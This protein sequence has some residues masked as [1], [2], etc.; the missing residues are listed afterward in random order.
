ML[1]FYNANAKLQSYFWA[2]RGELQ[3]LNTLYIMNHYY[4]RAECQ[5]E[6]AQKN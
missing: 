5:T 2:L 6:V 3:S 1:L 4:T